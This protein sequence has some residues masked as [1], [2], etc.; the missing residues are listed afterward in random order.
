MS[1]RDDRPVLP[2]RTTDED[3]AGWGERPRE[4]DPEDTR[5]FLE[6]KPPHHGD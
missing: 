6:E 4:D 1:E 2:D 5:R 3:D